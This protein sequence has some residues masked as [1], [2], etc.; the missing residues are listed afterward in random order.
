[1]DALLFLGHLTFLRGINGRS[2]MLDKDAR[3]VMDVF[4]KIFID[5]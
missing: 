2:W 5:I 1:M 3:L 4:L